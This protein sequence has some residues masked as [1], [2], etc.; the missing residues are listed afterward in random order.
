MELQKMLFV[1]TVIA[2]A[3]V[4][5]YP[6]A[7]GLFLLSKSSYSTTYATGQGSAVGSSNA[8]KIIYLKDDSTWKAGKFDCN[9]FGG[10]NSLIRLDSGTYSATKDTAVLTSIL[11]KNEAK[12][13]A[14]I[15]YT[16]AL[17]SNKI[18]GAKLLP[19]KDNKRNCAESK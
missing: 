18:K 11:C 9:I 8:K 1:R 2:T 19:I 13:C 6:H 16:Y 12:S 14:F 4:L 15:E 3:I 5:S 10:I 17:D 7:E